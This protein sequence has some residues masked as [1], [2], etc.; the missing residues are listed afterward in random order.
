MDFAHLRINHGHDSVRLDR[1]K[2][3]VDG[4]LEYVN[5]PHKARFGFVGDD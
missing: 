5:S 1:D 3:L 4:L 2:E